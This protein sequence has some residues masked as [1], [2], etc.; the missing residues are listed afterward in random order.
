[1][2]TQTHHRT[3]SLFFLKI[4]LIFSAVVFPIYL[5]GLY[6]NFSG[7]RDL[8]QEKIA[9]AKPKVDFYASRLEK[10][11]R[12]ETESLLKLYNN[13]DVK[14]LALTV[15][16]QEDYTKM[17]AILDLWNRLS[18]IQDQGEFV[19]QIC[20]YIPMIQKKIATDYIQD[21]PPGE[22]E[23]FAELGRETKYPFINVDSKQIRSN[24]NS[25]ATGVETYMCI[26]PYFSEVQ[27]NGRRQP[28]FLITVQVQKDAVSRMLRDMSAD[29]QGTALLLSNKNG[30]DYVGEA[31]DP[32]VVDHLRQQ[33][34]GIDHGDTATRIVSTRIQGKNYLVSYKWMP[35]LD[36]TLVTYMPRE[37]FLQSLERYRVWLWIVTALTALLVLLFTLLVRRFFIKPL[38]TLMEGFA[39]V[40]RGELGIALQYRREDAFG[41]LYKRFNAMCSRLAAL[42]EQVYEQKILAQKAEL[43]QLQYQINPHFL[44][45]SL[46]ILYRMAKMDDIDGILKLSQHLGGYY[47]FVT[48]SASDEVT[49]EAEVQHA[50]DYVQ[51][52]SI[53]Y[54]NRIQVDFPEPPPPLTGMLVPRLI[55]Q[56]LIE[57]AYNHGL[58]NKLSGGIL[59]IRIGR[60]E[61]ALVISVE[62]NGDIMSEETLQGMRE[63]LASTDQMQED[64]GLRNIHRRLVIRYGAD[65]GLNLS[66]GEMGGLRVELRIAAKERE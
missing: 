10:D 3:I 52:Q 37:S 29:V 4:L 42:I 39:Q 19:S 22:F 46:F 30:L 59:R 63:A 25:T 50:R 48:R 35:T 6:I 54:A 13:D 5:S 47:Q 65:S 44:Y 66:I 56:P 60:A 21:F 62:D 27:I 16:Q 17:K 15:G 43:K 26:M 24:P 2:A 33:M 51:I 55:L 64:G 9:S 20:I 7:Q 28:L 11:F 12:M 14:Y 40:E 61:D 57:N 23:M 34:V 31:A 36:S 45:N 53:R 49:L 8:E 38:D 32:Q 18:E 1:M 58:S 41:H